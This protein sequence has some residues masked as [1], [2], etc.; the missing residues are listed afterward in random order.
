VSF[1]SVDFANRKAKPSHSRRGRG[2]GLALAICLGSAT[3][4]AQ[5]PPDLARYAGTYVYAGK[6][7]DGIEIVEKAVDKAMADQNMVMRALAKKGFSDHFADTIMIEVPP[8][9]IGLKV[10]DLDKYTQEIGKTVTVKGKDGKQGRLTYRFDGGAITSTL[11]G[12]DST[13]VRTLLTLAADG[14]SLQREVKITSSQL[15]KPISYR[16]QYKRK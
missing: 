2:I 14:K 15:N 13:S 1:P 3:V 5:T 7:D 8:G 16:L 9:K 6:R 12:E 11:L 4:L 10:G